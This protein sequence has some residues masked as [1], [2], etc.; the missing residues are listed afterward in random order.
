M[1]AAVADTAGSRP[2]GGRIEGLDAWRVLLMLGGLLLHAVPASQPAPWLPGISVIS[3]SFRMGAFFGVSALLS[4]LIL[5]RR[6]AN[7]WF[8]T[9]WFQIGIPTL[10]S[11]SVIAP[12][13]SLLFGFHDAVGPVPLLSWHHLWFLVALLLYTAMTAITEGLDRR[14]AIFTKL[15]R[16]CSA[17]RAIQP[18]V[19]LLVSVIGALLMFAT[20]SMLKV[21]MP[22]DKLDLAYQCRFIVGYA[23]IYLMGYAMGRSPAFR[24]TMMQGFAWP[25]L[26]LCAVIGGYAWIGGADLLR[27]GWPVGPWF[28]ELRILGAAFGPVGAFILIVRSAYTIRRV[29]P[30]FRRLSD[31]AFTIYLIHYPLLVGFDIA[32]S[33]IGWNPYLEYAIAVVA[34]GCLSYWAHR[35]I[36][37]RSAVLSLLLNGKRVDL[38]AMLP[39]WPAGGGGE[40]VTRR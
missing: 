30:I 31:A 33:R 32:F 20:V 35:H 9:R 21:S 11:L 26:I 6:P 34:A 2:G 5:A 23:P 24:S 13:I 39:W 4:G 10:F 37:V 25:L 28:D 12:I 27:N 14:F 22:P 8:A 18:L 19:L 3:G 17:D 38:K 15:E 40:P 1:S 16:H 29:P 7:Q 36:V